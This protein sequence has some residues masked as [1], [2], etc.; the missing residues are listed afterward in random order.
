MSDQLKKPS[1]TQLKLNLNE[2]LTLAWLLFNGGVIEFVGS[3]IKAKNIKKA[4]HSLISKGVIECDDVVVT[5]VFGNRFDKVWS[6][7]VKN[8]R[9]KKFNVVY[10]DRKEVYLYILD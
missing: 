7:E 9:I 6:I 4:L 5:K 10:A 1:G 8:L 2:F 3:G